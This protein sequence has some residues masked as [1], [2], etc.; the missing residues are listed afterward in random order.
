MIQLYPFQS[1][2]VNN[3]R[4]AFKTNLR[5]LYVAPTGSGKTVT[6]ADICAK[7]IEKS[8]TVLVLSDRIEIFKQN[9]KAITKHNI[10]A[11]KVDADNK[12]IDGQAKLFFGMVETFN[13]RIKLFHDIKFDL[14]IVDEA[15]KQVYYKVFDAFPTVK[16]LG[17]TASPVGKKLHLYYNTLIQS[18]DIPEL[19]E[20]GFLCPCL[21]YE[22]RDDFSD[23]KTDNSGEFT[24]AS[25]FEH[26]N[27]SKLYEG[28]IDN[29]LK[30]CN[31]LKTLVFCVNIEHCTQTAKAF[32]AAGIRAYSLTA[33]TSDQERAW[34]LGEYGKSF[35]VLINAN[36]LVAGFDDPEIEAIIFNRATNSLP[37]WLQ[38]CGRGSR[39][40]KDGNNNVK[41]KLDGTWLKPRFIVID[42]GGNFS[43][44]GLWSQPRTWTLEPPKKR[45]KGTGAIPV[46][47]C[48][49]CGAMLP[50]VQKKCNFC[51]HEMTDKEKELLKGEL[52]EVKAPEKPK[53]PEALIGR[54]VSTCTI[55]ELIELEN[56]KAISNT[57]AW[58]VLRSRGESD[59]IEY[60]NTKKYKNGWIHRQVCTMQEECETV[61]KIEFKD[62]KIKAQ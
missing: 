21:G 59:I 24:E 36:I 31:G 26:F 28:I 34:I 6:F 32:N 13:R 29:Y 30:K 7:A 1:D 3:I 42:M 38:G 57:F 12:R 40:L 18:I 2:G 14:I 44:H 53:V 27:T 25:N 22:M 43:R 45:K 8:R 58:R 20:Q 23:L 16:T 39:V 33:K 48:K 35:F 50:A 60:A 61:G 10:K 47:E 54:N 49:A 51:G 11:C 9:L 56:A 19:I 5:V 46:R 4:E 17:V 62:F 37:V 41:L 15:H 55:A 52:I